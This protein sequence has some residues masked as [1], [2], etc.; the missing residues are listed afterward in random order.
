MGGTCLMC[1]MCGRWC[2]RPPPAAIMIERPHSSTAPTAFSPHPHA[3]QGLPQPHQLLDTTP[4]SCA[5]YSPFYELPRRPPPSASSAFVL[6]YTP[7]HRL[8]LLISQS[9][10]HSKPFFVFSSTRRSAGGSWEL[11]LHCDV[12]GATPPTTSTTA[13]P[14]VKHLLVR[15]D[16]SLGSRINYPRAKWPHK[17][18]PLPRPTKYSPN[19]V[20]V[21]LVK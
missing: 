12:L 8:D 13:T 19:R 15:R 6:T 4:C 1:L 9:T 3:P 14:P 10:H 21:Q 17:K 7:P 2:A 11:P 20:S 16:P 18:Y 5:S